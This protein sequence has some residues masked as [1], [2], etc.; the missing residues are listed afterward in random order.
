ML[1]LKNVTK[2]FPNGTVALERINIKIGRGDFVYIV[3]ESGAGKTTLLR[4]IH[5]DE[6]PTKGTLLYENDAIERRFNEYIWKRRVQLSYQDFMLMEERTVFEN[7]SLPLQIAGKRLSE[8][9][10]RVESIL[11]PLKLK[12]KMFVLVKELS[13]GEKQRVSLARAVIGEP[14]ILL[15]DEPLGNLD[16]NTATIIMDFIDAINEKG[17]TIIMSTHHMVKRS[18]TPKRIVKLHNGRVIFK[19]YV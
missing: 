15:L 10:S 4:L 1:E 11:S 5:R 14:E 8:I 3:G 2:I 19:G 12:H 6:R 18:T 9:H 13:G 17:T 16:K 7:V